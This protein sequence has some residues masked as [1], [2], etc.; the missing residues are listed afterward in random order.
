MAD[1]KLQILISAKDQASKT[2]SSIGDK[3]AGLGVG[4]AAA[5]TAITGAL[6]LTVNAAMD[7]QKAMANVDATLGTMGSAALKN[8][9]AILEAA[10]SAVKLGF[11]DED[12][13]QSITK[14]YQRTNDLAEAQ[15][16]SALAMDLARAKNIDLA[17]ATGLVNK[18]LSGQG[19]VLKQFGI[20]LKETATPL[21]ALGELQTLVGGQSK[22][23]AA[24]T[25]GSMETLKVTFGNL[26]ETIGDALLPVLTEF[27][28]KVTPIIE[29]V[30]EWMAA[31]PELANTIITIAAVLGPLLIILPALVA[32]IGAILSPIGLVIIGIGLLVAAGVYLYQH[33]DEVK[34]KATEIWNSIGDKFNEFGEKVKAV[35]TAVADFF[36]SIWDGIVAVFNFAV[37]LIVGALDLFLS[38]F[39]ANWKEHFTQVLEFFKGIWEGIKSAFSFFVSEML[40]KLAAFLTGIVQGVVNFTKPIVDAFTGVWNAVKGATESVFTAISET[41]K[42]IISAAVNFVIDKINGAIASINSMVQSGANIA[43]VDAPQLPKIPRLAEGGIVNKPTLAMIGEGGESEAVIPLSKLGNMM[44]SGTSVVV[45]MGGVTV[46]NSADENRLAD[47]V[48]SKL[49]Q[50]LQSNRYGLATSN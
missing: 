38:Q 21:E 9:D 3:F 10:A 29:K 13:A 19:G 27:V 48:A 6:A 45:N 35:F 4:M 49:A 40:P 41:I 34:A 26:Q 1:T 20:E 2:L 23:F 43:G 47:K 22:A 7:A 24:T 25:A 46:T 12:A 33:W 16:L 17:S 42:S 44:G 18:V 39:D 36:K 31:N 8:K 50:T 5:G 30:T 14:L 37:A 15:K 32:A 28:N 11:D